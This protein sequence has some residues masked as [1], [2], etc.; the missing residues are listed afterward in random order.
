MKDYEKEYQAWYYITHKKDIMLK[1]RLRL[2]E[3]DC[4]HCGKPLD[5]LRINKR[6][7]LHQECVV[8]YARKNKIGFFAGF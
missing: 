4:N 2:I 7:K 6:A 3:K 1:R 8:P 5:P